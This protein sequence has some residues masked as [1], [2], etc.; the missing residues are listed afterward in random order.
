MPTS[1]LD[2]QV[3]LVTLNNKIEILLEKQ[4]EVAKNIS[5]IKEAMY[6][7]E[8]GIFSRL[9]A[10]ELWRVSFLERI[11]ERMNH[12]TIKNGEVRLTQAETSLAGL[13]KIQWMLIGAVISVIAATFLK[14]FIS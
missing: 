4:E 13:R 5:Q 1:D 10:L 6:N 8:E 12:Y 7:P 11:D 2:H 9:R 3:S 14:D